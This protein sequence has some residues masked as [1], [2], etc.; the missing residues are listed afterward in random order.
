MRKI[1]IR[2]YSN[3]SVEKFTHEP[4][5]LNWETI[6]SRDNINKEFST[7]YNKLN[8]VVNRHAPIKT[9][10]KRKTKQ[11]SK[12]WITKGLRTSIRKNELYYDGDK[13]KYR[14]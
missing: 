2:D 10:S 11:L 4:L 12:P 13:D 9:I 8:R 3:F 1:K 14:I 7:F 6:S 5:R